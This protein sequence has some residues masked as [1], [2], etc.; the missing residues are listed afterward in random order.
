MD[1]AFSAT[2]LPFL[3][4]LRSHRSLLSPRNRFQ[5]THRRPRTPNVQPLSNAQSPHP[6]PSQPQ[7]S[8]PQPTDVRNLTVVA[9]PM[10]SGADLIFPGASQLLSLPAETA[11]RLLRTVCD[12]DPPEFAYMC[13]N[14]WGDPSE[15][16]TLC[17]I[18]D[19]HISPADEK[20][21]LLC[22]GISRLHIL[23]IDEKMHNARAQLFYDEP[24][25]EDQLA[26]I[27]RLEEQ[28]ISTMTQ[29]VQLSIKI[30]EGQDEHQ[31]ALADT[32]QRVRAFCGQ[33][34]EEQSRKLLQ[35]WILQLSPHLRR[36]ILSFI[37]IDLLSISFMDRRKL[38]NTTDT[39]HRL[40]HALR[41]LEPYV[42][43]LA[44]KGAIVSA[45]GKEGEQGS[46]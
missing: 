34:G 44:A 4:H 28:L 35:P 19:V 43:E 18:D 21:T 17:V 42:K 11:H 14:A 39:G 45:L 9:L 29:I 12:S 41:G 30:S 5:A 23:N 24:P 33:I 22:T 37:V 46:S 8:Q 25:K 7:P 26:A 2:S 3:S 15:V 27:T 16:A 10:T 31:R 36:E 32:L 6:H 38:L 1:L 20:S 40:E 13:L